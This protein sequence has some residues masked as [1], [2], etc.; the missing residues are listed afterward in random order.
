MG[1]PGEGMPIRVVRERD[2][3]PTFVPERE[4]ERERETVPAEEPREP[5]KV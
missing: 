3:E 2:P 5:V 1:L 4:P